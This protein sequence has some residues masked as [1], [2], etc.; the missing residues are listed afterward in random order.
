[1]E[2]GEQKPLF[3]I[4]TTN[5]VSTWHPSNPVLYL[6][7]NILME[8]DEVWKRRRRIRKK[9]QSEFLRKVNKPKA[10]FCYWKGTILLAMVQLYFHLHY[11]ASMSCSKKK[12]QKT[13]SNNEKESH[14]ATVLCV[15]ACRHSLSYLLI[16]S[17]QDICPRAYLW[18]S[19]PLQKDISY[20]EIIRLTLN[21]N[22]SKINTQN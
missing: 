2:Q 9:E 20:S 8:R 16:G 12:P 13:I 22:G 10:S 11:L 3:F 14:V 17:V 6:L 18:Q 15:F 4:G 5:P 21:E 1:M 19:P 7:F